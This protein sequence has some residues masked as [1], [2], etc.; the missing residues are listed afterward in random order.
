MIEKK[1][2]EEAKKQYTNLLVNELVKIEGFK[3]MV[4]FC[5][6]KLKEFPDDDPMP[7]GADEILK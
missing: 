6:K 4:E 5:E 2:W 1:D 7:E 3:F